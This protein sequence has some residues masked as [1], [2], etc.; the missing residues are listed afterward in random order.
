MPKTKEQYEAIK[1][2]RR[3]NIL[4][5][6]LYLFAVYGYNGVTTD[7]LSKLVGCSHGLIYHYFPTK[8]ALWDEMFEEMVKPK[9]SEILSSVNF[10]QKSKFVIQDLIEA[11]INAISNKDSEYACVIY[12]LL[13][14]HLQRSVLPR[15]KA[16]NPRK[17]VF[18]VFFEVIE[19]GQ[20]EGEFYQN[21]TKELVIAILSALKGLSYTRIFEGYE[22][23]KAPK[24]EIYVRMIVKGNNI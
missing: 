19:K 21:N 16:S 8:E 15:P 1:Q 11:Y 24:T 9:N 22:K 17:R 23:F 4:K 10:E 13:N 7:C 18:E 5:S 20:K 2:E 3:K 6:A 14:I 12:L